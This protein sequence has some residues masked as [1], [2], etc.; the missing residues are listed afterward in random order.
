MSQINGKDYAMA[1]AEL[2][3]FTISL[4]CISWD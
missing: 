2:T 3:N 4:L 1:F